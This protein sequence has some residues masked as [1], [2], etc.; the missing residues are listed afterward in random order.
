MKG[1]AACTIDS[2]KEGH[3]MGGSTQVGKLLVQA[4]VDL[5]EGNH[6][7]AKQGYKELNGMASRNNAG[8]I[9]LWI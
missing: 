8:C 1:F 9:E 2:E 6:N 7:V 3:K 5:N 4:E